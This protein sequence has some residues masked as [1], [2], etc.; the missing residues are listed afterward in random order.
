MHI[1]NL[2][3]CLNIHIFKHPRRWSATILETIKPLTTTVLAIM[4]AGKITDHFIKQKWVK[5]ET[6]F[7]SFLLQRTLQ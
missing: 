1:V 2:Y 4:V 3:R 5:I 7:S 6:G